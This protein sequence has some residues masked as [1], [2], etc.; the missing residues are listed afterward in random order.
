M[1]VFQK[2]LCDDSRS[3]NKKASF[4]TSEILCRVAIQG[5]HLKKYLSGRGS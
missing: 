5:S 4:A 3:I 1:L 2:I